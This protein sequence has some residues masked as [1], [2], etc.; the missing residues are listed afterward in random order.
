[1]KNLA[2]VLYVVATATTAAA[3]PGPEDCCTSAE[4]SAQQQ[5]VAPPPAAPPPAVAAQQPAG[6]VPSAE[7]EV[8][9]TG[10]GRPPG[11]R[12]LHGIRIGW[13]YVMN[14]E[15]PNRSGENEGDPMQSVKDKYELK[16]PHMMLLGYEGMYR[17]IGHSWL[18][19]VMVGN[20]TVAGL[21]QSKFI[22]AAS[23]LIGAEFNESFQ[24]GVGVNL[25]PDPDAPTHAIFA[26]GWTPRVGSIHT[27]V[28]FFFVPEPGTNGQKGNHRLGA[29]VGVTW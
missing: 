18:N 11:Q 9:D 25:T 3:Q 20:V 29:T 12:F 1:M 13:T 7:P 21:E 17:I 24:L 6:Y 5:P 27:P 23:G 10:W 8:R 15:E 22:P 2:A 28:H 4:D 26:A 14:F 16:T 19:I